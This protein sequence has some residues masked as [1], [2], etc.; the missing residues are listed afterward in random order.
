MIIGTVDGDI[1]DIGKNLIDML[2]K[3]SSFDVIDIGVSA[4]V[5]KL[6]KAARDAETE[7]VKAHGYSDSMAS[8]ELN[9][10]IVPNGSI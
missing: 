4:P 10:S 9:V 7:G 5:A 8:Q 6:L 1:H 2:L 3:G